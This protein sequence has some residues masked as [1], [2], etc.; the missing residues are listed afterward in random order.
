MSVATAA[1]TAYRAA[2]VVACAAL[3]V[4]FVAGAFASFRAEQR[5][6]AAD[7]LVDGTAVYVR[8]LLIGKDYRGAVGQLREYEHVSNDRLPHEQ[9]GAVLL[10]LGPEARLGFAEALRDG[11]PGYAQGH[12]QLGVAFEGAEDHVRAAAEFRE[13]VRLQPRF[14]EAHNALGVALVND[15]RAEEAVTHFREAAT[16]GYAPALEN[17]QRLGALLESAEAGAP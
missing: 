1:S 13:A 14:A 15:G 17:L 9:L 5:L 12:Y 3:A 4:A 2:F 16:L 8:N 6:P 10:R 11:G 7:L